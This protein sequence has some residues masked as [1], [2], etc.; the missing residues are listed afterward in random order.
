MSTV[1]EVENG[2]WVIIV[3]LPVVIAGCTIITTEE[4]DRLP[5]SIQHTNLLDLGIY[6][7]VIN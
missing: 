1:F 6:L 7:D 3:A 4:T 2:R 5:S